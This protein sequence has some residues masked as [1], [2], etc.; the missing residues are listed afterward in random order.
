MMIDADGPACHTQVVVGPDGVSFGKLQSLLTVAPSVLIDEAKRMVRARGYSPP[1]CLQP[2]SQKNEVL[3]HGPVRA[4]ASQI[5]HCS[6]RVREA[7]IVV[8]LAI[9]RVQSSKRQRMSLAQ[10]RSDATD[11]VAG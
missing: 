9:M 11:S 8:Q 3:T 1:A 2:L 10:G 5:V 6:S 4:L 7:S